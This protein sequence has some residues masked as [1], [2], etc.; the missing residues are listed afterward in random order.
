MSSIALLAVGLLALLT[1]YQIYSRYIAR[2]IYQL[3]PDFRTPAHEFEDGVDFVPTNRHVLFGHHFTSVAGAAPIVGPAIAVIW[4][5]L[6]AFLWVV[7]GT[8]FAGAV[9]DFGTLWISTRHKANS[10]GTLAESIVGGRARVLFLLIIF[11]LLLLVNAVFAVVI[12]NLL[13]RN[14]GAVLPVWGSLAVALVVGMLIY[15]TKLG[16]LGPSLA[17]LVILY[18]L[19]WLGQYVPFQ[20]P[21]FFGFAPTAA[22]IT[23]A[24]GDP[25][26][27]AAAARTD[28]VRAGWVIILFVYAFFASVLPVWLLLQPRDY[29]NSHQL[30][31]ALGIIFLGVLITNPTIVAPAVNTRLPDDAP[32]WFPLLFITIACGA[33]SG[34]HG[35]VASGTSAKQLNVETDARYIGYGGAIGE[36]A[37]ALTSILATTAGF[38]MVVGVDGWHEHYGTWARASA[39]ATTAFVTGVGYL[40]QGVG[41]PEPVAVI[42]AAVVVITFAATTMDTGVRLQRYIIS[43]LGAEYKVSIAR[44]RWF[45]TAVA[46]GSCA[47]MALGIDRGAGGMRLWPLFGTTNQLTGALSLLVVTLFLYRLRRRIWVTAVPMAFLLVMTTWAMVLNLIRYWTDSQIVLLGVGGAVFVLEIWLVF[48][49]VSAVRRAL[50][51]RAQEAPEGASAET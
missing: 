26:V 8:I 39:G 14:P 40:A 7:L 21:D 18:V 20:L 30:F 47:L 12:A 2:R 44:N 36:G 51:A 3:D 28:G 46:V 29:V 49:A 33:I 10:I 23:A 27:A 41:I 16:I 34:F 5:W 6:P 25:V 22:Q 24:A 13:L 43:E 42:F 17:A 32:S 45:A 38:A 4:G 35:L 50:A 1:G 37:L 31:V 11:F 9:H 19:I 15:R 48:E